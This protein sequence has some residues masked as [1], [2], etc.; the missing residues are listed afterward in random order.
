MYTV[1]PAI[2]D[3]WRELFAWVGREAG[4]AL[5]YVDHAAPLPLDALWRRPDLGCAF[6]CG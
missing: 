6:M 1:T 3:R 2:A 5:D 4:I